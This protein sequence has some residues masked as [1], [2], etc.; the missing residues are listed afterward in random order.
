MAA[1][2]IAGYVY[3]NNDV[4]V[5]IGDFPIIGAADAMFAVCNHIKVST[6]TLQGQTHHE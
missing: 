3:E 6:E 5:P 4:L 1:T 2:F